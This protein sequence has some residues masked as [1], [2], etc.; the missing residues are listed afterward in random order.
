M[1]YTV[2]LYLLERNGMDFNAGDAIQLVIMIV[3]V[4]VAYGITKGRQDAQEK[5]L[6]AL[7]AM[8]NAQIAVD[9]GIKDVLTKLEVGQAAMTEQIKNLVHR[10]DRHDSN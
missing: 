2:G 5:R 10:L 4:G 3:A 8:I 6:D 1:F 7:E 9:N